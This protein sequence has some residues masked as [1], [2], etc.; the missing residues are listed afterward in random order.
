MPISPTY[1]GVYIQ[2]LPNGVYTIAG[3]STSHTAFIEVS[4]GKVVAA[5]TIV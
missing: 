5:K 3:V 1:P 4:G 2:E